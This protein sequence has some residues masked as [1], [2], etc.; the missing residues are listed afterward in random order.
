LSVG[1]GNDPNCAGGT[2]A[3]VDPVEPLLPPVTPPTDTKRRVTRKGVPVT[4]D[5][6][7]EIETDG[8]GWR[9]DLLEA[10]TPDGPAG[11]VKITYIPSQVADR[12][13]PTVLQYASRIKGYWF[14]E[15]LLDRP[16][17]SWTVDELR[18]GIRALRRW[19]PHTEEQD[20]DEAVRARDRAK[21]LSIWNTQLRQLR[22]RENTGYTEF[23][24][25][26]VDRPEIGYSQ[27]YKEGQQGI[28]EGGQRVP[29]PAVRVRDATRQGVATEM[30]LAAAE[31]MRDRGLNL[32][33]STT[34]TPAARALWANLERDG[35]VGRSESGRRFLIVGA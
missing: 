17:K 33:A 18:D 24:A 3:F 6:R 23:L 9:T 21:V 11:Y 13:Y 30:Y 4:I 29:D 10:R 16:V 1:K 7:E 27:T 34:Q 22:D 12:L 2:L 26:H 35:R 20:L 28:Y 25:Y 14:P 32:H 19:T 31:W 5:L 8:R 15:H